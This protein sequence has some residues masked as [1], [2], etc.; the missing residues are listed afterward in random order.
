MDSNRRR[1]PRHALIASAVVMEP[2]SGARLELRTSDISG[3]GCYLDTINALPLGTTLT[4]EIRH[5]DKVLRA[6]GKVAHVDA[7]M[8]MGVAFTEMEV[9]GMEI[10]EGWVRELGQ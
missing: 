1:F 7:N 9:G 10:L 5:R 6:K 8:G 3:S 4:I 2:E